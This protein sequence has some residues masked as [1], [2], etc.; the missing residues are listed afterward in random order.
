MTPRLECCCSPFSPPGELLRIPQNQL[1]YHS[2][3]S[4]YPFSPLMRTHS[5]CSALLAYPSPSAHSLKAGALLAWPVSVSLSLAQAPARLICQTLGSWRTGRRGPRPQ[6][7][8]QRR[9][10]GDVCS[11]WS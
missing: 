6:G 9:F 4:A 7:P 5:P 1:S 8:A 3:C 11:Q 2:F 10:H